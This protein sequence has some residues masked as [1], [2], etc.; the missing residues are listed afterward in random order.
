MELPAL[1]AHHSD[2]IPYLAHHPNTPV[3]TLLQP[4][5]SY[6]AKLRE[7][8]AQEPENSAIA[9]HHVN[10][11]P[12]YEGKQDALQIRPR[13]LHKETDVEKDTYLLPLSDADRKP[14]GSPAIVQSLKEFCANFNIFSE[15]SLVDL[16]WNNVVAAGSSVVTSLLP[17]DKYHNKSKR[18]LRQ[19]YHEKLAPASDVDLFIYGLDERQAVEKI[20][21]IEARI[22]DA[23]LSET[24]TIR[25]KNAITIVS[26]YPT[27]H[28]QIVLRLYQSV[29]EILTGFDVDCSCVAFDGSQVWA[30]PR[31]LAAFATQ[32][33]TIDLTRRSP[34]YENRLSKYSHRGFEVRWPSLDRSRVDPTIFERS[35]SR[36]MGLARLL[37]LEKLPHPKD[38]DDY[39]AQRREERGRPEMHPFARWRRQLPG[40]V[41]DQQP[42]DVAEW[43]D[44][45]EV[46]SY[47]T[48]TIPY[49]PKYNAKKIDK[50]LFTKDLLL[51]AEWNR[52]KDRETSLHRHPAFFGSVE[53]VI[54]DCCGYCP[55]AVTDEDLAAAEKEAKIFVSGNVQFIKDDPGRQAIGSF[56]PL[57][58]DDWTEMAYVG[59]TARLCQAI[60]DGDIEHVRDWCSQ[61][62][63]DINSRD[64]TGRTPLQLATMC[65]TLEIVQCLI[66]NGARLVARV[67][68]GFT[69]LHIAAHRG[70]SQMIAALLKKSEGNEEEEARKEDEKRATRRAEKEKSQ[71]AS[72]D[73]D[74]DEM[75]TDAPERDENMDDSDNSDDTDEDM[76]MMESDASDDSDRMTEGSFVRVRD[77]ETPEGSSMPDDTDT[78]E[79]DV[80]DVNVLAWDLPVSP[81][82]LAI[83]GGHIEVIHTLVEHFGADVLLP[84][85]LKDEYDRQPSEAILTLVLAME[86]PT[87]QALEATKAL[88]LL[89]ASPSQADMD[90]VTALHYIV[91]EGKIEILNTFFEY[92][93]PA[94]RTAINHLSMEGWHTSP[95]VKT[96]L[97]T[98]IRAKKPDMVAKLLALGAEPSITQEAFAR[99]LHRKFEEAT[100]NPEDIK[101]LFETSIEQ[102]IAEAIFSEQIAI[103]ESLMQA[104]ASP[105]LLTA[106]GH[107]RRQDPERTYYKDKSLLDYV[108][109]K[110]QDLN[111]FKTT[112]PDEIPTAPPVL[113]GD[114][115]YLDGLN[116][117]TYRYWLAETDLIQARGVSERQHK[118]HKETLPG[119]EPE[120]GFDL[121]LRSVLELAKAFERFEKVMK[122]AGAKTFYEM[123]PDIERPKK[124]EVYS[125]NAN[126]QSKKPEHYKTEQNFL[127]PDI[128][129]TKK[130]GYFRLFQAAWEGDIQTVKMLTL[131][132]WDESNAPLQ[133]TASDLRRFTPFSLAILR[134][135]VECA[136][137]ILDI[138]T[139]QYKPYNNGDRVRYSLRATNSE[140]GS[141]DMLNLHEELID[142]NYTI[143]DIGALSK[144]VQ[145][146]TS[147]MSL[148]DCHDQ[149]LW[150]FVPMA[151]KDAKNL[152]HPAESIYFNYWGDR[153][154]WD[155]HQMM[156]S[157]ESGRVQHSLLRYAIV[158]NNVGMLTFLLEK[159]R[160]LYGNVED[161]DSSDWYSISSMDFDLAIKLGRNEALG[162]IIRL[163]AQRLP[164]TSLAK[165]SGVELKE[166]PKY[167]QGLSV[168]G[169]KRKDWADASRGIFRRSMETLE[170]PLTDVIFQGNIEPTEYF[171]SDAPLRR[172]KEFAESNKTDKRIAQLSQAEG[173]IDK[174]LSGWLTSQIELTLHIAV[175]SEPKNNANPQLEFLV[176]AFPNLINHAPQPSKMAPITLAFQ[177]RRLFA[178]RLLLSSG[179][180]QTVR[181]IS[182][183]NLL[184]VIAQNA[185]EWIGAT[186]CSRVYLVRTAIDLLDPS[187]L[188]DMF[189][190]RCSLNNPLLPSAISSSGAGPGSTTPLALWLHSTP[191]DPNVLSMILSYSKGVDLTVMD[192]A[193]DYPLHVTV[194]RGQ[195]D[196]AKIILD[197]KP[198]LLYWENATGMTPFDILQ[199]DLLKTSFSGVPRLPAYPHTV[200]VLN[201]TPYQF[202]QDKIRE[203]KRTKD[204]DGEIFDEKGEYR[205]SDERME[206]LF[207][208]YMRVHPGAKRKLVSLHD[209]NE[210]AKRLARWQKESNEIMNAA[211]ARAAAAAGAER[212]GFGRQ[213]SNS[214]DGEDESQ[215][216]EDI[217]AISSTLYR[218]AQN[219]KKWD[220]EREEEIG[221]E[222]G[223][224]EDKEENED[225]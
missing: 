207:H 153:N 55:E 114:A 148:I 11:V 100:K 86:L 170:P 46:S 30:S 127:V 36:V 187:A 205:T 162:E 215:A 184:H 87:K 102:P 121:K 24:T 135:H 13:D 23:I 133:V 108:E 138:A 110:L 38:R 16:D 88:L 212:S 190:Q 52:P 4:Y 19:Y 149:E 90:E 204:V 44:E 140:D 71:V 70:D 35:F 125:A 41:K 128:D 57:T 115:A 221:K 64:H 48:F 8:F 161:E 37:V 84:V 194:R 158:Q 119:N 2:F 199:K 104:G 177:L 89:G 53:D 181:D 225:E 62:E 224:W 72:K 80:Y 191:H 43:V 101:N 155:R 54:G 105:N 50:L 150:R 169:K 32:I 186:T 116:K 26:E 198:E 28:V 182:G 14:Q 197:W 79:P 223:A 218:T 10:T 74:G 112:N 92:D 27:R 78:D 25:T 142:A 159:R 7:V 77:A 122:A 31:A 147:P 206:R 178:I 217:L 195:R 40:N 144:N 137:C 175:M 203:E 166:K 129:Q 139:V 146:R 60:V 98:A 201:W 39:M 179:A 164:L 96:P 131:A 15:S 183:R 123:N 65:G 20:K 12:V 222:K 81:L 9:N 130:E 111:A 174:A 42:D 213:E 99:T 85:K 192:G 134:G 143:E 220:L 172:Y 97:L 18:A 202:M 141:D 124:D 6:E 76:D 83:A 93:A 214:G 165:K 45:D 91:G 113:S 120:P 109:E 126:D 151:E 5:K 1:P 67:Y 132:E 200:S 160:E 157:S 103:A 118:E 68:D 171:L 216:D 73:V 185:G 189:L 176:K 193:G 163:T 29:S 156:F 33:N 168:H 47:H 63:G 136:K 152:F 107:R 208:K 219:A 66:D 196:L 58:D 51:N 56:N 210:V 59:N 188:K 167:Y 22:R 82:H 173:G 61:E 94:A 3:E 75:K 69:A 145:S 211:H 117:G 21:Q 154:S 180:D 106:D 34:S 17:V 95:R 209:A 49:G